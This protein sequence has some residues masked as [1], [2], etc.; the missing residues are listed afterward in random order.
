MED[1]NMKSYIVRE[2]GFEALM[3]AI[4]EQAINDSM[5][6]D[7]DGN[8]TADAMDAEQGV[9]EWRKALEDLLL[10]TVY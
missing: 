4:I 2:V 6:V 1:K 7:E 9:E 10:P 5:A 8:K 3:S